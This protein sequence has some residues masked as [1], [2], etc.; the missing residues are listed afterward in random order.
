MYVG[1]HVHV[2]PVL[3]LGV[4]FFFYYR[5]CK[6]IVIQYVCVHEQATMCMH[7]QKHIQCVDK[8]FDTG[9]DTEGFAEDFGGCD[10]LGIG[11][12]VTAC[13]NTVLYFAYAAKSNELLCF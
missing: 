13:Y 3:H 10:G 4:F 7:V 1:M 8:S 2:Q 5:H 9:N 12:V 11:V 6:C